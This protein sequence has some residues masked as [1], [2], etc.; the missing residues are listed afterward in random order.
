MDASSSSS[1]GK[2]ESNKP[3]NKISSNKG[4]WTD[5]VY[6]GMLYGT[7]AGAGAVGA[8]HGGMGVY[9]SKRRADSLRNK[10]KGTEALLM[11]LDVDS[12]EHKKKSNKIENIERKIDKQKK[13]N[14]GKKLR[15]WRGVGAYGGSALVGGIAGGITDSAMKGE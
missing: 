9:G 3:V 7:L 14:S 6:D 4:S 5:G 1:G 10:S 15:G 11:D 2:M 8:V 13:F 12:T